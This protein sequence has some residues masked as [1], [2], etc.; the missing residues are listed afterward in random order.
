M[1]REAQQ[2]L[3]LAA[4]LIAM[5][6]SRLRRLP[7]PDDIRE[8]VRESRQ[9]KQ[10]VA[11][12]RQRQYLA[13]HLRQLDAEVIDNIINFETLHDLATQRADAFASSWLQRLLDNPACVKD[14]FDQCPELDIAQARR[15]L[16]A[17]LKEEQPD[18]SVAARKLRSL[19]TQAVPPT[20]SSSTSIVG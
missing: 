6:E 13:K 16:R 4:D 8:L 1:R 12:K 14:L 5:P 10:R 11:G 17:A 19:L 7:L 3:R 18:Q 9:V 20:V 2:I 15:L